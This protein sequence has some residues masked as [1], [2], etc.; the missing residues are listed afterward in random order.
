MPASQVVLGPAEWRAR[1]AAHEARADRLVE[2][3]RSRAQKGERD[4]VEDFLFTYYPF[5]FAA[6]RRWTPGAGIALAEA[7]E[8]VADC[9]FLRGADGFVRVALPDA[10]QA[11]RLDFSLRLCRA[12]ATRA[13]FHGCFGLHEWAM[14]YGQ[15]E[16]R[17]HGSWPLRLGAEGTDAV[18]RSMPVRC[19]HYDAFRFFTPG[20]RPLNKIAPTL[21]ARV[22]NEQPGCVHVTMDLFKWAMKAQPW[23][24]AELAADAFELAHVARTVDMRASPYDFSAIGLKP[25]A[26]E[27]TEG[28]SEYETEQRRLSALAEPVRARLIAELE[29]ALA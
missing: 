18:V 27:T 2:A 20:A 12:V 14:V 10:A 13:A 6:V 3:R 19:T 9:R 17:R 1:R 5:R 28:R 25:I 26:I 21:E 15:A 7:D 22:D 16:Q 11:G 24:S 23:V 4:P 29:R 8:L